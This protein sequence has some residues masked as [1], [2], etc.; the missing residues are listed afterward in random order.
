MPKESVTPS[1]EAPKAA[2]VRRRMQKTDGATSLLDVARAA[3]V[4]TASA[5]RALG[6]PELVSEGLRIRVAEA[7]SR[8]GYV[9]NAAARSLSTQRSGLVGAVLADPADTIA[10]QMLAAAERCLSA[11]KLG[12][13]VRVAGAASP[14]A[15]CAQTLAARGVDALLFAGSAQT[16]GRETWKPGGMLPF[17]GCGQTPGPDAVPPGETIER[18]G[19]ALARAYLQQLG[20]VHVGNLA[21]RRDEDADPRTGSQDAAIAAEQVDRLD[22]ADA[23]RAGVRRLIESGMTAIVTLSDIAA[24]AALRECRATGI[25]V[26]EQL[27]VIGWGDTALARCI[28]PQLTSVRIPASASGQATAEYLVATLSGRP[29]TWPDLP[30]KL[31]IRESTGPIAGQA[32]QRST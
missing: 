6:R 20:H 29:F 15:V 9:A 32:A 7:A 3:R 12:M 18:R 4:S 8:L 22:A 2:T 23:V 28:D 16:P 13:L 27:S 11:H 21:P 19:L 24:A 31:V 17:V 26:P 10:W 5:S 1:A 14:V 25:A 30:L